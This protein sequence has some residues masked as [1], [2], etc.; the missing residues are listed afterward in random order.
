MT[1][2][3]SGLNLPTQQAMLAGNP[4]DSAIASQTLA[5]NKLTALNKAVSGGGKCGKHCGNTH[6][7]NWLKNLKHSVINKLK[8]H[9]PTHKGGRRRRTRRTKSKMSQRRHRKKRGGATSGVVVPQ[10]TMQYAPTGGPGQTPNDIIKQNSQ[11]SIQGS[12]NAVYDKYA[13]QKGG[14]IY[15]TKSISNASS[16]GYH[17][18]RHYSKTRSSP[19]SLKSYKH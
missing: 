3:V 17:S 8:R 4:R 5:N 1:S 19:K 6:F 10:F 12:S 2:T 15:G 14:Y 11:T 16:S 9:Q 7:T 18:N 13:T